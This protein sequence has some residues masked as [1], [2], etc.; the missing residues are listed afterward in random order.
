LISE[1]HSAGPEGPAYLKTSPVFA[2]KTKT[3]AKAKAKATVIVYC[4]LHQTAKY[5]GRPGIYPRHKAVEV[6]AG[7]SPCGMLF[8]ALKA[9]LRA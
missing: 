5:L 3:K 2:F 7:F 9:C 6:S 1:A 8:A 4:F